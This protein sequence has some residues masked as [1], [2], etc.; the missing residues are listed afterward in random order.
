LIRGSA[1]PFSQFQAGVNVKTYNVEADLPSLDEAR[2][3]VIEEMRRARREGYSVLKVIHGWGSSGKGG[4][5]CHGLR[6]SFA[7]RKKEGAIRDFVPGESFSIFNPTVLAMLEAAPELRGDPDL[8][9]TNE[10]VTLLW[11]K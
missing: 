1:D 5:L 10:G 7:L 11:L 8:N 6:K 4:T 2:R 9:S 3:K